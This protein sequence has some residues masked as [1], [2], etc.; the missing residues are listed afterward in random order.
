MV[1]QFIYL[2]FF[3]LFRFLEEKNIF[4]KIVRVHLF[5]GLPRINFIPA[6]QLDSPAIFFIPV[7]RIQ[8]IYNFLCSMLVFTPFAYCSLHF[9]ALLYIFRN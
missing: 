9:V 6:H 3:I 1:K 5:S 2:R 4:K 8:R 7:I